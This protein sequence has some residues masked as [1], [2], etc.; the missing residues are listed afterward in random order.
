MLPS[1]PVISKMVSGSKVMVCSRVKIRLFSEL[2]NKVT[3]DFE[4]EADIS[5]GPAY[6]EL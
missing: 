4:Y 5:S 1:M 2:G 3:I 6:A